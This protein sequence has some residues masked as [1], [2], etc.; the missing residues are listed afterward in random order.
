MHR[1][2]MNME[3]VCYL[4]NNGTTY[5]TSQLVLTRFAEYSVAKKMKE[6]KAFAISGKKPVMP[7]SSITQIVP[8]ELITRAKKQV[9]R[10]QNTTPGLA[11]A[12]V[13][14]SI[15]TLGDFSARTL[16]LMA[17][18]HTA[19]M[20]FE[21]IELVEAWECSIRFSVGGELGDAFR[22]KQMPDLAVCIRRIPIFSEKVSAVTK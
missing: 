12:N 19:R 4:L 18:W 3:T 8:S 9:V 13:G 1:D 22:Q 16:N 11:E 7:E 10:L 5:D 20:C 2:E 6:P 15:D 14:V 21:Q 17:L